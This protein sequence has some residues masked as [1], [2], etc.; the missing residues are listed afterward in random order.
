MLLHTLISAFLPFI[1]LSYIVEG[2]NIT[3]YNFETTVLYC[4]NLESI[5]IKPIIILFFD[6]NP[7]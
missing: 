1:I 2:I 3:V 7:A 5:S 6:S 4:S